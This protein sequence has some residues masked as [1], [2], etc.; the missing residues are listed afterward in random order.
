MQAFDPTKVLTRVPEVFLGEAAT[1]AVVDVGTLLEEWAADLVICGEFDFGAM[2]AAERAG[3]PYV[4]VIAFATAGGTW[5][6]SIREP[7]EVL[8]QQVGLTPDPEQLMLGGAL[9]VI[10]FPKSMRAGD[11]L[12]GPTI[13]MR[14]DEVSPPTLKAVEWLE[15]GAGARVYVTLG[16]EFN[17][18]SGDLFNRIIDALAPLPVRVL[19]TCGPWVDPATFRVPEG[20]S[21]IRIEQY[22]P[23]D[24]VLGL[25]DLVVNHGGSSSVT[26]A[27]AYGVPLLV[28]PLGADQLPN[29]Q[30]TE[31]M[32]AGRVLD[33]VSAT[34]DDIRASALLL[35]SDR[36][37]RT[38][39]ERV[40]AEI[41]ASEP[42]NVVLNAIERLVDRLSPPADTHVEGRPAG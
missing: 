36:T 22:V 12:T 26:G 18:K 32:G 8:R 13:R 39:A 16:T 3:L 2:M 5:R 27:L 15:E 42:A 7:L 19:V 6:H 31:A 24:A 29:A 1:G 33:A 10:P 28:L 41:H 34:A 30:C 40:R 4:V 11:E 25:V 17:T 35:L 20:T 21:T 14:P 9:T 38:A 37:Y 23:Q